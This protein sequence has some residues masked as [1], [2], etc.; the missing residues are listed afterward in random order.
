MGIFIFPSIINNYWHLN[1]LFF[2]VWIT[3][4]DRYYK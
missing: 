1:F 3:Y 4:F 2:T